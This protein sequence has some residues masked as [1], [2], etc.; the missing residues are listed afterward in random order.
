VKL[1]LF[2]V[3]MTLISTGGA[4][5]RALDRAFKQVM[6]LD[7]AMEGIS[8]SGKTDPSIIREILIKRVGHD[9]AMETSLEEVLQAYVSFLPEEV[10]RS[11][12]YQVLPGIIEI[13]DELITR[14]DALI[15]LATGNVEAG[16]RIK[17]ERG[18]LNRYFSFGGFGSDSENR[19]DLVRRAA[20]R[21]VARHGAAL[22][23]FDVFVIGDTPLDIDAGL[24][25]GFRTIGVA[26]G[27]YSKDQLHR[28]GA[29]GVL[30]DFKQ[31]RRVFFQTTFNL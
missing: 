26:T 20:E 9:E 13:L 25:A 30:A 23:P 3:D 22:N 5:L 31:D 1:L 7:N 15:G 27:R 19:T 2:D 17:L 14:S 16:A 11:D 4:G 29:N 21:A 10:R 18:G 24:Q 28:A 12:V 6:K 8:P